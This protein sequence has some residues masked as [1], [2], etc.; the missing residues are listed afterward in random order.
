MT[1][2]IGVTKS[3]VF[4]EAY[5][6]G[7]KLPKV[8]AF[9][10][11]LDHYVAVTKV[12]L[13]GA[14]KS[15]TLVEIHPYDLERLVVEIRQEEID[16]R[17]KLV[18]K[19]TRLKTQKINDQKELIASQAATITERDENLQLLRDTVK[20]MQKQLKKVEK[21]LLETETANIDALERVESLEARNNEYREEGKDQKKSIQAL[22]Q[23][24]ESLRGQNEKLH[25][26]NSVLMKNI[27][28]SGD[29]DEERPPMRSA[30]DVQRESTAK[31]RGNKPWP[32]N[33]PG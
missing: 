5:E 29:V 21:D 16:V 30:T 28:A 25:H 13:P 6:A 11:T 8:A 4:R 10:E 32:G 15:T 18:T 9:I 27:E 33:H 2:N 19:K 17:K 22:K 26:N 7:K 3:R 14:K 24:L 12:V 31:I 1:D 20:Q 23:E